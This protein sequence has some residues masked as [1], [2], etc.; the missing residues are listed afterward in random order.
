MLSFTL[1]GGHGGGPA[2]C[3]GTTH[4]GRMLAAHAAAFSSRHFAE[5]P[6]RHFA[7]GAAE[8]GKHV[9]GPF[10][11]SLREHHVHEHRSCRR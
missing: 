6:L 4:E 10:N 11:G 8:F 1:G 2:T 5:S 9:L 7:F 3:R